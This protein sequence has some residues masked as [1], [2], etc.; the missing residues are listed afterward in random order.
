MSR[1]CS[2]RSTPGSAA[3][4]SPPDERRALFE[5]AA[6]LEARG[7]HPGAR[8][9]QPPLEH[10]RATTTPRSSPLFERLLAAGRAPRDSSPSCGT[11]RPR[12]RRSRR[13]AARF[14]LVRIGIAL[15][16]LPPDRRRSM[17]RLSACARSWSSRARSRRCA[18]CPRAAGVSYGFTHRT[19]RETTLALVPLGYADGVPRSASGRGRGR[20]SAAARYP[21]V[22]RIAMDQFVVD[23]G[24]DAVEVGDRVVRLGR[25]GDGSPE[26]RGVGGV[27]GHH[28]LRDR[29]PGR[30][31]RAPHR[32]R[33]VIELHDP[34][35]RGDGGARRPARAAAAA[36]DLVV[37][38]GEL[39]AGKT[40][41][42]RGLGAALGARGA[43]TSPTFV[44]ARSHPTAS[45]I[46]LVHVDAYRLAERDRARRPRPRLRPLDRGRRVGRRQARRG[47]R[48]VDRRAHRPTDRGR[49]GCR[50]RAAPGAHHRLRPPLGPA[51][52]RAGRVTR[53]A[54]ASRP[55]PRTLDPCCSPSTPRPARASP[56]SISTPASSRRSPSPTQRSHA[57][58]IGTLIEAALRRAGVAPHELSGVVAGMGPGPFTGLRVGIAAARAFALGIG[59][60]GRADRVA[61]RD[62]ARPRAAARSS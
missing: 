19:E 25:P 44:L 38:E 48:V 47:R 13:P 50:G 43:I 52:P 60:P 51:R 29:D 45:G 31:A 22:G 33:A 36:G 53:A 37:L 4:G 58:V 14:D 42:T 1:S 26:R 7:P 16:G 10:D 21:V 17:S 59:A 32:G 12:R 20:R 27:G 34:G 55:P 57:E 41:L 46:P 3:T 39:G 30:A 6:E 11:S 2:S 40:T 24:D 62:R 35:R 49:P 61:R 56:S 18:G 5:R 28:Q 54:G 15:Y 9:L 8:H 23:V